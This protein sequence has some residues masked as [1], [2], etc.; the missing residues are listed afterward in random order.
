MGKASRD[1]GLRSER[2]VVHLL[3]EYGFAA[4]RIPLSGSAGG[5][6]SGDITCPGFGKDHRLEVKCRANGFKEIYGWLEGNDGLVLKADRQP[7]LLVVRL[8]Y[9]ARHIR[10]AEILISSLREKR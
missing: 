8:D 9:A 1:K 4:E 5:S 2:S 3:Q 7:L 6:F 10:E